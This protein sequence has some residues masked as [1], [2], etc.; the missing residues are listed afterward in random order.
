MSIT[1]TFTRQVHEN[2]SEINTQY[3]SDRV[4]ALYGWQPIAEFSHEKNY[5]LNKLIQMHMMTDQLQDY[6]SIAQGGGDVE[7]KDAAAKVDGAAEDV[8]KDPTK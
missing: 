6:G 3:R 4:Q 8:L 7:S 5:Y 1:P 2:A